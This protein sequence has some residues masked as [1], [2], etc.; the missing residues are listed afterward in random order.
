MGKVHQK[1]IKA[2]LTIRGDQEEADGIRKD[3]PTVRKSNIKIFTVIAAREKWD[4]KA[5]DVASAFLQGIEIDRDVFV[6]PPKERRVPK[7]LWRLLKPVYGLVDAPRGWY[8]ALDDEFIKAGCERSLLDPAMYLNFRTDTG[9]K[10]IEGIALTHVDDVLHGG[11][12]DF[13]RNIM[14]SV[15]SSFKFGLEEA[16]T[17]RYVG[18][19][20]TQTE[21]G[22]LIDQDH[23]VKGLE[24]PDMDVAKDLHVNDELTAEGQTIFRGCVAKILHV[25]YQS[26]PD[27]CFEAK[28]LSSKFGKATKGDLKTALKKMQKLQG[29]HTKMFFPRLG[30]LSELTFV[31]YGDAGIKSMPDKLSSVGGQVILLSDNSKGLACVLNWRSK[32]LVRKVIS[33]LAGEALAMVAAIGE[34]VYNKAILKQV[35]GDVIDNIPVVMFTDSRNLYEAVHSTALVDDAWLIPDIA[36]IKDALGNGTITCLRRVSS[37]NMLANCLTKAGASAEQLLAVVQT[38]KYVLVDGLDV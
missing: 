35:Y 12:E 8:L 2:R 22:I 10:L 37:D 6:L 31:G 3:S 25:G 36:V 7:V 38:G 20:M 33:S 9:N 11:G 23:Y 29:I 26:R 1:I 21:N 17:F 27:I 32:K 4:I 13:D 14:S 19:N 28:C 24:L 34:M 18:M 16:E 30:S 5:S 15:K